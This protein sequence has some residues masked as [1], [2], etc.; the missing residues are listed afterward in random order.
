MY[1]R[2]RPPSKEERDAKSRT[3]VSVTPGKPDREVTVREKGTDRKFCYDRAF[4]D[5]SKQEDVFQ[6]VAQPLIKQVRTDAYMCWLKGF[7]AF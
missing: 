3:I 7:E 6:C 4:D 5:I 1:V 2:V